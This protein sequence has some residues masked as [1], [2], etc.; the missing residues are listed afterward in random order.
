MYVWAGLAA[1]RS[2]EHSLTAV[3]AP[4]PR[5]V[6]DL[7]SGYGRVLRFL[8]VA[9]QEAEIVACDLNAEGARFCARQFQAEP[10]N[11][12]RDLD[13][14]AFEQRFDLIWCGSL[15][16]HLNEADAGSLIALLRRSLNARGVAVVTTHG[17][18]R[19]PN[20]D[21]VWEAGVAPDAVSVLR[22]SVEQ[23]GFGWEPYG[24]TGRYGAAVISREWLAERAGRLGL[25]EAWFERDGWGGYQNATALVSAP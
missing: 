18:H 3:G 15:L 23:T 16:T 5:T 8:R 12:T 20:P 10:R 24:G 6:L 22:A 21:G 11:S 14:V 19:A 7:P 13:Q 25:T 1:L 2:I 17:A 4:D 9:Y